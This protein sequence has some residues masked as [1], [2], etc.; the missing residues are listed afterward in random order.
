MNPRKNEF[1]N[2]IAD[3]FVDILGALDDEGLAAL[4]AAVSESGGSGPPGPEGPVGDT[5]QGFTFLGEWNAT[6]TYAAYD[7]V[8]LNGSTMQAI[9]ASTGVVPGTDAAK[10]V[11]FALK[12]ADGSSGSPGTPGASY[13]AGLLQG[14]S[15]FRVGTTGL[16]FT[17]SKSTFAINGT[18]YSSPETNVTLTAADATY[19][20]ID[21]FAVNSSGA[22]VVVDGIAASSP[23][24]PSLDPLTQLKVGQIIVTAA[25]TNANVTE[26]IVYK[27][28]AEWTATTS[29]AS[30]VKNSTSN[31]YAGSKCIEATSATAGAYF[32]LS[33]GGVFDTTTR[34]RLFLYIRSKAAWAN[35]KSVV[36]QFYSGTAA[37]GTPVT[38]KTGAYN[39]N[40]GQTATY[41]LIGIELAAFG[42]AGISVDAL[43]GTVT[44]GGAAIGF[45]V[46][47]VIMQGGVASNAPTDSTRW[48]GA[49]SSTTQYVLN[50]VVSYGGRTYIAGAT[51]S[52]VA[53]PT[54]PWVEQLPDAVVV[55]TDQA[56]IAWNTAQGQVAEV[57]L[58]ASR[59]MGAP[60]N[61]INGRTYL[62]MVIQGGTGSYAI[63]WNAVFKWRGG[64]VPTGTATVGAVDIYS[65]VARGGNLYGSQQGAF[66]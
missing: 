1:A 55:L 27:E 40:S 39:F 42:V 28:D 61:V 24:E 46:D 9:D 54:A 43:R 37:R 23:A 4:G 64:T 30:I 16:N 53:P 47:D 19:N 7:V 44:G 32:N 8:T 21:V 45:Y 11:I 31:P 41:Q 56:T 15:V 50:D 34:N 38:L 25:S 57:T 58:T 14:G 20:R 35:Q 5:G 26:T 59:T 22:A 63:T 2:S 48:K 6:T 13:G 51:I 12:G 62:L 49:Y 18:I 65:F 52:G 33:N 17:V 60:S 29:G 10:W 36:L 3:E 66:A